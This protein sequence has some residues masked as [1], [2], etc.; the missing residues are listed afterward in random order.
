MSNRLLAPLFLSFLLA[1]IGCG[2]AASDG[3]AKG[4]LPAATATAPA[5]SGTP[6]ATA[7]SAAAP[8]HPRFE[9]TI[10]GLSGADKIGRFLYE[11]KFKVVF[12]DVTIPADQFEGDEEKLTFFAVFDHCEGLAP[13]EKP[14]VPKCSGTNVVV[15]PAPT[16]KASPLVKSRDAYRLEG[17]FS[18]GPFDGPNQGLMGTT[19]RAVRPEDV[20]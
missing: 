4:A 1:P 6:A 7:S 19:I 13:G 5:P 17:Y 8:A 11:N 10:T 9:G 20:K 2:P 3:T 14:G 18:I 15:E 12:L 16:D